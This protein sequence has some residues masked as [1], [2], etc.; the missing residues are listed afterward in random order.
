MGDASSDKISLGHYMWTRLHQ[1]GIDTIFGVP[2]DFNLQFLDSIYQIPGLNLTCNQNELNAAYAADGYARVKG[3]P[4]CFVT[5][6]GVG[7]LSALNGVAGAMCENVKVIHVV[8]QTTRFMQNNHMM[9]HHSIGRQ[10][11]HQLYN[12]A[13]AGLRYAAAELWDIETAPAEIDR[14]IRECFLKSGP[15]YIFLPLDLSSE[16]VDAKLLD[17]PIDT[18]PHVDQE[19]QDAAVNAIISALA[20]AKHPSVIVDGLVQRF[21]AAKEAQHFIRKLNVPLYTAN[22]GKGVIDE[23]EPTY[24]G[25]WNGEISA[26]GL[27][28]AAA[29]ADLIVTLGYVPCDLNSAGFSRKIDDITSIHI[30]PHDVRVKGKS[31]PN[32]CIKS[33]LAALTPALPTTPTHSIPKPKLPPPR[34][35]L[36]HSST[37]LTQSFLWPSIESFL[38]PNDILVGETGTANWGLCDISFPSSVQLVT[39]VYYGSIGFATAATL[40]VDVARRELEASGHRATGRTMLFTGDGSMALTIQELG[41]MIKNHSTA[42]VFVLNNSGYTIE[43]LIWGARQPYN[44]IVPHDYSHLLQLY[45]H[46]SPESSFHRAATKEELTAV[47]AKKELR[48]PKCLQLVELVLDKLDSSWK[49]TT[50][51]AWR[52]EAHRSYLAKEGFVDTYG[53]WGLE[54]MEGGSMKWS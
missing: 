26:P 10:P 20:E 36:D 43:R 22:M 37:H 13:S 18:E 5:T 4:G 39:Q 1:I 50:A 32:T 9:I 41:T 44:D 21:G 29:Q 54:G 48:E 34:T 35:P 8:G 19:A 16:M 3:V 30:N 51:L 27:V 45:C 11:D 40:G 25:V 28:A 38:R 7:E 53:G 23:T 47:L 31:Y 17:T 6:H 15:V 24:V 14:V 12:K 49:L 52:S 2:G 46:P 33:L 42:I